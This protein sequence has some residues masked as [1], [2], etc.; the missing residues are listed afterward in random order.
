MRPLTAEITAFAA[1]ILGSTPTRVERIDAFAS[2]HVFEIDTGGNAYIAKASRLH[3]ALS[4]EVWACIRGTA[5]GAPRVLAVTRLGR[6]G[7]SVVLMERLPGYPM[8][9]DHPAHREVG[10]RLRRL[11]ETKV[12]GFGWLANAPWNAQGDPAPEHASWLAF[13]ARILDEAHEL[14]RASP[15]AA[16]VVQATAAA[17]ARQA[18][19]LVAVTHASLCHG[20]LKAAHLLC[21]NAR[22]S[23][24]IDW[25][26]AVL[27][28]PLWDLARFA[29]RA[30]AGSTR[31][32]IEGY[33]PDRS[34]A[35]ALDRRIP[36]YGALWN[37]VD[38]TV[39][40]RLG[41]S[42][43]ATVSAARRALEA[44]PTRSTPAIVRP[45]ILEGDRN[46]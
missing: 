13:I 38:A 1:A 16:A 29:H 40:L 44:H 43:D 23:G 36:L 5:L 28:D 24:V 25:G 19:E 27:A 17:V 35:D 45:E 10:A 9:A 11:H 7:C 46:P 26:D 12:P 30:D 42:V 34:T 41:L 31:L 33:R 4:S 37:L 18:E 39:D 8:P 20:D 2:N 21:E 22:L 3:D 15:L 6:D 14:T 32:M